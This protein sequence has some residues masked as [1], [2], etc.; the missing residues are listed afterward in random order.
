MY[1]LSSE[2]EKELVIFYL[3]DDVRVPPHSSNGGW[4]HE[5]PV[6]QAVVEHAAVEGV[7]VAPILLLEV[8][9][10]IIVG[11]LIGCDVANDHV[12]L[13][14]CVVRSVAYIAS[15]Q[16]R[17]RERERDLTMNVI[18]KKPLMKNTVRRRMP[19]NIHP[20]IPCSRISS[21]RK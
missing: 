14:V 19:T 9:V 11:P 10:A 4:F 6:L 16:F 8:T 12:E 20:S 3:L 5:V 2:S 17:E 21:C 7:V 13:H 1:I 18:W 15:H